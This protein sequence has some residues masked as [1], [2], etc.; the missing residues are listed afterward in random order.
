MLCKQRRNLGL[1][2]QCLISTIHCSVELC[3]SLKNRHHRRRAVDAQ[4]DGKC[5]KR[6]HQSADYV[7]IENNQHYCHT[8]SKMCDK[9]AKVTSRKIKAISVLLSSPS[10]EHCTVIEIMAGRK[11][12][13]SET[14]ACPKLVDK[15]GGCW[16]N[17]LE[18]D[19]AM[20]VGGVSITIWVCFAASALG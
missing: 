16:N 1:L 9:E 3:H 7:Q 4:Q 20:V 14:T 18:T 6:H 11:L 17:L 5:D 15:P 8:E 12:L 13:L 2:Y 19:E 10:G